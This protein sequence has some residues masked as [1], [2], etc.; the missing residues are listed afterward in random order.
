VQTETFFILPAKITRA[1][2]KG[3]WR[4]AWTYVSPRSGERQLQFANGR[5]TGVW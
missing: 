3:A 4:E 2:A 5:L 1:K